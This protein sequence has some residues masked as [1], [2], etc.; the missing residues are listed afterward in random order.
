MKVNSITRKDRKLIR[1]FR[2]RF[3]DPRFI[4]NQK[5]YGNDEGYNKKRIRKERRVNG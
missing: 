1:E 4:F 5:Q 2:E 3:A